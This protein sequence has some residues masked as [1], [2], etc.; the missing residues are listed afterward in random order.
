M[1][2]APSTVD[3]ENDVFDVLDQLS[4][5]QNDLLET[6]T[7]K[8]RMMVSGDLD[9]LAALQPREEELGRRLE[10]CHGQRT[11]L[12]S[13]AGQHGLP[14]DSIRQLATAMPAADRGRVDAHVQQITSQ[15]RLL[16]HHSLTTWVLAQRSLLH[17]SQ[18]LEIL[19]T[20][21]QLQPTYSKEE[22]ASSRG[23]LVDHA[24]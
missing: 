1:D 8:Q 2:E 24:A 19:A 11:A 5:V 13:E 6:I 16:R 23:A 20:G 10:E 21:G 17:L 15:M 18:L 4:T 22:S 3:L 12:L 9:G 14:S 7:A